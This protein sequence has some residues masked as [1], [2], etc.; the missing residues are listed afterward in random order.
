M[1]PRSQYIFK[2][3][4]LAISLLV[5]LGL[6]DESDIVA[7]RTD[8]YIGGKARHLYDNA[9][10]AI[11]DDAGRA[12]LGCFYLASV[13]VQLNCMECWH[14]DDPTN[15]ISAS[16]SKPN[17]LPI[18]DFAMHQGG[19][20]TRGKAVESDIMLLPLMKYQRMLDEMR[21]IYR[22]ERSSSSRCRLVSHAK[23]M[24]TELDQWQSEL[25]D[26]LRASGM[27]LVYATVIMLTNFQRCSRA[28][29]T[30]PRSSYSKWVCYTIIDV[31]RYLA[32]QM[33]RNWRP[34]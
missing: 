14:A 10:F 19:A 20:L 13:S 6:D 1:I 33:I 30:L 2:V 17:T 25:G 3:L 9:D 8:A 31:I 34:A 11:A 24:L 18:S 15:R 28:D 12:S 23:R 27:W 7:T 16:M 29:T 26:S 21:N 4:Q 32:Q 5:D 22:L